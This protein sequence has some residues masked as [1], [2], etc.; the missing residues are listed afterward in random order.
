MPDSPG[1]VELHVLH[2][3]LPHLER[4]G[5]RLAVLLRLPGLSLGERRS[6]LTLELKHQWDSSICTLHAEMCSQRRP[7]VSPLA[8]T[9]R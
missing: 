3:L 5:P 6:S 1:L 2:Q 9:P 4:G 8:R 7:R